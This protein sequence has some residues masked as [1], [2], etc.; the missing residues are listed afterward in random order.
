MSI[1]GVHWK[2][3]IYSI[4][5]LFHLLV[6][7]PTRSLVLFRFHSLPFH[8]VSSKWNS[9]SSS[10]TAPSV[11][12][13]LYTID[14]LF[15]KCACSC[16][17]PTDYWWKSTKISHRTHRQWC[18]WSHTVGE[19]FTKEKTNT[20]TCHYLSHIY[21]RTHTHTRTHLQS[22]SMESNLWVKI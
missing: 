8:S 22:H 16:E 5:Y 13:I 6:L 1:K 3:F 21:K 17:L 7:F 19:I 20:V 18:W 15:R 12:Q 9:S 10:S 4:F 2:S 14:H 11:Q